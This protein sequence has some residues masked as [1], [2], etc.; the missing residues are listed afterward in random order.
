M[1]VC[2]IPPNSSGTAA[3]VG[4]GFRVLSAVEVVTVAEA[5]VEGTVQKNVFNE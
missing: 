2:T 4:F 1:R 5:V 3:A